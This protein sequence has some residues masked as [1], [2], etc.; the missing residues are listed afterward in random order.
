[1]D[2]CRIPYVQHTS[3]IFYIRD[4]G[5]LRGPGEPT[6][7]W[8]VT[9]ATP[10]AVDGPTL[11]IPDL[12]AEGTEVTVQVVVTTGEGLKGEGAMT[13]QVRGE[14]QFDELSTQLRCRLNRVVNVAHL[15]KPGEPVENLDQL[16]DRV[17]ELG[18]QIKVMAKHT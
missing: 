5:A 2:P 4:S 17:A 11:T 10:E 12:P 15:T 16:R 6:Y 18:R 1:D 8:T 7:E 9:G 13:F 14:P 3:M